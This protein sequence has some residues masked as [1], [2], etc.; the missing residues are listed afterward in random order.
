MPNKP[1]HDIALEITGIGL[2]VVGTILYGLDGIV[3]LVGVLSGL[4]LTPDLDQM[5]RKVGFWWL[6]GKLFKHRGASHIPVLGTLTRVVY[7]G[8]IP[9]V[10]ITWLGAWGALP[11]RTMAIWFAGLC[12][13]DIVHITM[14]ITWSFLKANI[15]KAPHH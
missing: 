15:K 12:I 11:W 6:Y 14:D 9:A 7:A 1:A 5:E 3:I 13:A 10:A 2:G 8:I 4:V